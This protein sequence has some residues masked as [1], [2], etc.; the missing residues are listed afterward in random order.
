MVR[1]KKKS[2]NASVEESE[3]LLSALLKLM[4]EI[5]VRNRSV[6]TSSIYC[7]T[8]DGFS[9]RIGDHKGREKYSY[10]WNL[11]PQFT[12]QGRWVKEFSE[13]AGRDYWRFYTS[14]VET[15]VVAIEA[16]VEKMK[17]RSMIYGQ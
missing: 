8:P 16:N 2:S 17:E 5:R 12:A 1:Q 6:T 9:L 11:G 4:P 7:K 15:L 3:R 14:S 13:A 10:K